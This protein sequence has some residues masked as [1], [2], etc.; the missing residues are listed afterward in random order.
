[1]SKQLVITHCTE[2]QVRGKYRMLWCWVG[3]E[4]VME[5]P[6]RMGLEMEVGGEELERETERLS[7]A[8]RRGLS[9]EVWCAWGNAGSSTQLKWKGGV[10]RQGTDGRSKAGEK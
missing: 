7:P 1:M 6:Q 4:R 9:V 3:K 8:E 2:G 5:L 10:C